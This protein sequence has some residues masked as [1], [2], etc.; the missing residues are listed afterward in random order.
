VPSNDD[1]LDRLLSLLTQELVPVARTIQKDTRDGYTMRNLLA[2]FKEHIDED[3]REFGLIRAD[4]LRIAQEL[5]LQAQRIAK[6]EGTTEHLSAADLVT[7]QSLTDTGR[8]RTVHDSQGSIQ[9]VP[10]PVASAGEPKAHAAHEEPWYLKEPIKSAVTKVLVALIL[11]ML[12]WLSHTLAAKVS[13][14]MET[15]VP[16]A[17]APPAGH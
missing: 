1:K 3:K 16:S 14:A 4:S 9:L 12:G 15:P 8:W 10:V 17:P 6:I 7:R 11:V 13:T 2:E 5:A